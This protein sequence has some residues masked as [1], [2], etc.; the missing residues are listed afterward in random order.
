[1][2]HDY[3]KLNKFIK[4]KFG[5]KKNYAD[6]LHITNVCLSYKL[7]DKQS[8][9]EEQITKTQKAFNLTADK[10]YE[11]FHT[12]C[13][14]RIIKEGGSQDEEIHERDLQE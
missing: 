10:V 3:H 13:K 12:E 11:L 1:M 6:F 7:G 8:F 4:K 14:F 9:T 5:T 2:L